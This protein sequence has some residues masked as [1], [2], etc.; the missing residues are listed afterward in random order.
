MARDNRSEN[1]RKAKEENDNAPDGTS[2]DD[3]LDSGTL[4][5]EIDDG[6]KEETEANEDKDGE[7]EGAENAKE[8]EIDGE[9]KAEET[10]SDVKKDGEEDGKKEAEAKVAEETEAAKKAEEEAKKAEEAEAAKKAEPTKEPEPTQEKK[11]EEKKPEAEE[12]SKQLSDEEAAQLFS[13]WR[14]TTEKLLAEHHYRLSEQ[15]VADFNENPAAFIPRYAARVYIDSISAAFQQFTTYLPR[16]VFQVLEQ[17]KIVD[18]NE[19][20]F[21]GAWPDL[22]PHRDAVS[23]LGKAY[24]QSNPTA[25][26]EQFIQEVGA[27]AMVALRLVPKGANGDATKK[28]EETPVFKP[29]S[30]SQPATPPAQKKPSNPFEAMSEEFSGFEE[31]IDDS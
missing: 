29:A 17:K 20:K 9:K 21:Y 16:M 3:L 31:E 4:E 5:E 10:P 1:R 2:L 26:V 22:N 14:G 23:R 25:S 7:V 19:A 30:V 27:Q 15:D 8:S 12:T 13:D 24:R 6:F 18:E 11:A 28:Q